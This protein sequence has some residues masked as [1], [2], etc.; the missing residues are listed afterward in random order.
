[1]GECSGQVDELACMGLSVLWRVSL[2][3][4]IFSLVM[5]CIVYCCSARVAGILSEG[6]FFSKYVII[7]IGVLFTLYF[8]FNTIL[9][10]FHGIAI[11]LSY[12]FMIMQVVIF[13]DLG[14]L[15]GIRWVQ[16]YHQ[17][18]STCAIVLI[19][20]TV[21]FIV[22]TLFFFIDTLWSP[23]SS[24][25]FNIAAIF[26]ILIMYGVQMLNFNKQNSLLTSSLMGMAVGYQVWMFTN[27]MEPSREMVYMDMGINFVLMWV[28]TYG[29]IYGASLKE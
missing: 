5:C 15:W 27:L 24:T 4:F 10:Y 1:M 8:S 25:S 19:A 2:V 16:V 3:L 18:R 22:L 7:M 17:G 14:Y 26:F 6:L 11:I 21:L 13:I 20:T 23:S 9:L 29:S 28:T 12:I